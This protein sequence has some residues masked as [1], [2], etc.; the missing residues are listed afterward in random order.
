MAHTNTQKPKHTQKNQ[1]KQ[2][3]A[4]P[5]VS[6]YAKLSS[7]FALA[8][9]LRLK[10]LCISFKFFSLN[11]FYWSIVVL[12]CCGNLCCAAKWLQLYIYVC[13]CVCVFFFIFFFHYDLSQVTE[14]SS[15]CYTV[16]PCCLSILYITHL[17]TPN[18]QSI[19]LHQSPPPWQ[20]QVYSLCL[21][22]SFY[23]ID[24]FICVIF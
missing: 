17:L 18:S 21:W 13:V 15:L 16:G 3:F 12:Q 23:F 10:M 19:P 20:P 11:L 14:Y 24:K 22:V 8:G 1:T 7:L 6:I 5:G 4:K 9:D 2:N